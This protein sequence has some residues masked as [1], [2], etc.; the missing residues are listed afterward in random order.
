MNTDIQTLRENYSRFSDNTLLKLAKDDLFQ[1]TEDAVQVLKEEVTKRGLPFMDIIETKLSRRQNAE[2]MVDTYCNYIRDLHCP[3]CSSEEYLLNAVV[4]SKVK[5]YI[6]FTRHVQ[7]FH[8][9]CPPCLTDIRNNADTITSTRGWWGFP[10]GIIETISGM[11]KNTVAQRMIDSGEMS[12]HLVNWV[13]QE[14][15]KFKGDENEFQEH[16]QRRVGEF[17][18]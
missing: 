13:I 5:S 4:V 16:L 15:T 12:E 17:R 3:I 6:A 10:F 14:L 2:V 18:N 11:N 8:I 9:G 1:L 7:T